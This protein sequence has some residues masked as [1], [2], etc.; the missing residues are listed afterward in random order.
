M[1]LFVVLVENNRNNAEQKGGMHSTTFVNNTLR[2]DLLFCE[3]KKKVQGE[4]EEQ[5]G[6]LLS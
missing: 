2:I 3:G 5:E 4:K 6:C 1:C